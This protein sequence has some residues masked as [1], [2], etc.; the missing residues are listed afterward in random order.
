M[1]DKDNKIH[2]LKILPK[3]YKEVINGNKKFE[4][5]K[6]DRGFALFDTIV[7]REFNGVCFTGRESTYTITYITN[8]EQK[9]DYVVFSISPE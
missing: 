6:N 4:I 2:Y 1:S 7:L 5:R 9:K 3:Y 8:F